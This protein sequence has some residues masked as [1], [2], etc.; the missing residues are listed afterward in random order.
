MVKKFLIAPL[1][2]VLMVLSVLGA[3]LMMM[4]EPAKAEPAVETA[5]DSL[6]DKVLCIR[7]ESNRVIVINLLTNTVVASQPLPR[8]T[9]SGPTIRIPLPRVTVTGPVVTV[10]LPRVT[11]RVTL[12]AQTVTV[13]LPRATE[14]VRLPNETTTVDIPGQSPV[15]NPPVFTFPNGQTVQTYV[16]LSP[17]PQPGTVTTKPV[18]REKEV[19][20]SVPQAVGLSLG[21]FLLGLVL[22]LLAIYIAYVIGYKNSEQ[23]E[24]RSWR[25]F[26]RDVFGK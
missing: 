24:V 25:R 13:R 12:P 3:V 22:G 14:T 1:L 11:S 20:V 23:A 10:R 9:V 15:V 5:C 7:I 21:L 19:R 18:V 17:T 6:V 16:T 8:V 2:T 4:P 26:R